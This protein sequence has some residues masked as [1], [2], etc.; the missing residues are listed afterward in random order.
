MHDVNFD[1]EFVNLWKEVDGGPTRA[2]S[3][4]RVGVRIVVDVVLSSLL[5]GWRVVATR[6]IDDARTRKM[7]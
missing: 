5:S 2:R 6:T 1:R 3:C 7:R 4:G